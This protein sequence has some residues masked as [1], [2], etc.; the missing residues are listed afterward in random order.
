V[1][2]IVTYLLSC[3]V[4]EI[5]RMTGPIFPVNRKYLSLTHSFVVKF[6]KFDLKKLHGV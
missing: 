3:T 4:S 6:S 1:W 5:C 2:I